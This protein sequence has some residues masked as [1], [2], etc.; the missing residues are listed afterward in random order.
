MAGGNLANWKSF[1]LEM[2][3][4]LLG[5]CWQAAISVADWSTLIGR[6]LSRLC[7]DWLVL[8]TPALLWHKVGLDARTGPI[9]G[10]FHAQKGLLRGGFHARKGPIRGGFMNRKKLKAPLCHKDTVWLKRAGVS[11]ILHVVKL[12]N[13]LE[14]TAVWSADRSVT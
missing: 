4:L 11:N 13:D 5:R 6:G 8:L 2:A 14:W 9:K 1:G 7:S 12:G 10:G 3:S